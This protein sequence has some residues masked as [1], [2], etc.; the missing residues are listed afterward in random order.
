MTSKIVIPEVEDPEFSRRRAYIEQLAQDLRDVATEVRDLEGEMSR[1]REARSR[2]ERTHNAFLSELE[3]SI[4]LAINEKPTLT[5]ADLALQQMAG[6]YIKYGS[7]KGLSQILKAIEIF[8]TTSKMTE[9]PKNKLIEAYD[10]LSNA[11]Y[12]EPRLARTVEKVAGYYQQ[13][14][15]ISIASTVFLALT[16]AAFFTKGDRERKIHL[17]STAIENTPSTALVCIAINDSM[18]LDYSLLMQSLQRELQEARQSNDQLRIFERTKQIKGLDPS[19]ENKAAYNEARFTL[20]FS[21][22]YARNTGDMTTARAFGED[23]HRIE[24]TEENKVWLD[25][26]K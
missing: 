20:V 19:D 26:L 18:M 5:G 7:K 21:R 1:E 24:P 16:H 22:D 2:L 9:D 10:H 25:E 4:T 12:E 23:L 3:Q 6:I 13:Q 8:D 11:M 17:Y 14:G 15:N